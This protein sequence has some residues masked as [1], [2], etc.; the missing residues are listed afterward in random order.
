MGSQGVETQWNGGAGETGAD[1]ATFL[2]GTFKEQVSPDWVTVRNSPAIHSVPVRL[3]ELGLGATEYVTSPVPLPA[4]LPS[5]VL[6][7]TVTQFT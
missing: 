6:P 7:L 3:T 5:T 4:V 2:A 1:T